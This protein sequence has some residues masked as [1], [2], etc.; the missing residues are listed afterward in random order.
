MSKKLDKIEKIWYNPTDK[1]YYSKGGYVMKNCKKKIT[2]AFCGL[3]L[4]VKPAQAFITLDFT[5]IKSVISQITTA[6]DNL[7]QVKAQMTEMMGS[8][9]AIG[10]SCKTITQFAPNFDNLTDGILATNK[11]TE[12][13]DS[14]LK[15]QL[16]AQN[17]LDETLGMVNTAQKRMATSLV[18]EIEKGMKL[19][20]KESVNNIVLAKNTVAV[21][22]EEEE[23]Y[24]VAELQKNLQ[25]IFE[26]TE[27]GNNQ[28]NIGL[29]D[30]FDETLN[31]MNKGADINDEALDGLSELILRI[32]KGISEEKRE[33]FAARL[34]EL[35]LREQEVSDQGLTIAEDAKAKYNRQYQEKIA[36]GIRNYQK[37]VLAYVDDNLS[38]E[39]LLKAGAILRETSSSK[40]VYADAELLAEYKTK[41]AAVRLEAE[42]LAKE[43]TDF[44]EKSDKK[45]QES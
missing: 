17:K 37:A 33:Y 2:I 19:A 41:V 26:S 24:D 11:A 5:E 8:L 10:D 15:T 31:I 18:D 13:L 9:K 42:Q 14:T 7:Q 38:K 27:E 29:N 6:V 12:T 21:E 28:L 3:L 39:E 25:K 40:E 20:T 23:S 1:E 35:K 4:L 36:D 32:N 43:I 30:V 45:L 44:L 16:A 22:E 34:N